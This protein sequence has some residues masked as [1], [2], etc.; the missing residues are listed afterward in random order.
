MQRFVIYVSCLLLTGSWIDLPAAN[1]IGMVNAGGT[2][3]VDHARVVGTATLFDGTVVETGRVSGDLQLNTGARMQLASESTGRVFQDRL[4]LERGIGQLQGRGYKI[5][6]R[7]LRIVADDPVASARVTL[8]GAK[9][10]QVAALQG[11]VR[12]INAQGLLVANMSPGTALEFEPQG[13]VTEVDS[14][15]TGTLLKKG[16]AFFL[17]DNTTKVTAELRGAGLA[18]KVG[19]VVE[20]VGQVQ[21]HAT[22]AAG[23]T[24]VIAVKAIT[25]AQA[26]TAAAG[27]GGAGAGAAGAGTGA[28]GGAASAA[29]AAATGIGAGTVAVVGGVAAAGT[30]AGLGIT[31]SLPGQ[32]EEQQNTSR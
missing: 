21:P 13:E 24:Q 2:F 22:A 6:A 19:K 12:V 16:G 3:Q 15:L 26:A 14:K 20:V 10:V 27:A 1:G 9:R 18:A 23:A 29:G 32:G 7:S 31:G 28:A 17:T 25:L 8:S 4:V 30:V 11:S 5:E